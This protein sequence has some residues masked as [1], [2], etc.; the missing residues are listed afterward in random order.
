MRV[1]YVSRASQI[2]GAER[3]LQTM[4]LSVREAGIDPL[5]ICPPEDAI[6]PWTIE[7]GFVIAKAHLR[8][9]DRAHPVRWWRSVLQLLLIF[10]SHRIE[11]VHSNQIYSYMA[12][13][14]A[15]RWLNLARVC[16]VR[17]EL[18]TAGISWWCRYGVEGVV[19]IS[20]YIEQQVRSGWP[21]HLASP[22]IRTILNPVALPRL[23]D[24]DATASMSMAARR[25]WAID[26]RDIVFA[27]IGQ[28]IEIKGVRELLHAVAVLPRLINWTLLI[29][30]RDPAAGAPY[31]ATCH[32]LVHALDL[33][34]RVKLVGYLD[35]VSPVYLAMDLAVVPSF[36]EPLGRIPLEAAAYGKPSLAFAAGGLPETIQHGTT[37]WLVPVGDVH[38]LSD[39][40][41]AFMQS[42]STQMGR[43]ARTMAE[44]LSSPS[45]HAEQVSTFYRELL[46]Q[47][48]TQEIT[49]PRRG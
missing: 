16:H 12:A 29:A 37:G 23:D 10:R 6:I 33:A 31:E 4:L 47:R 15:A 9:P 13:S 30:G 19:C 27:Y 41:L 48:E 34:Q 21:P 24:E 49:Q 17:N 22:Q 18:S 32:E 8:E 2:A 5:V 39:A 44:E 25:R 11:I 40:L 14:A 1:A 42:Q 38:A 46:A 28:L 7:H 20:R 3:S 36:E 35:D 43:A 45:H 26:D